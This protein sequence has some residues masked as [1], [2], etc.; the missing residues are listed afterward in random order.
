MHSLS[1]CAHHYLHTSACQP[2][3]LFLH[4]S[5]SHC[6]LSLYL[7][8]SFSPSLSLSLCLSFFSLSKHHFSIFHTNLLFFI[9]AQSLSF[10]QSLFISQYLFRSVSPSV[11]PNG[12]VS[13]CLF[14]FH[15]TLASLSVSFFSVILISLSISFS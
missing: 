13:L 12:F 11:H 9:L 6:F 2:L 5:S 1:F 10:L 14:L 15:Y 3:F 8:L 4:L 7:S